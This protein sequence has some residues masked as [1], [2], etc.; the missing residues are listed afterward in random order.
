MFDNDGN[1]STDLTL[2]ITEQ[3]KNK[4]TLKVSADKKFLSDCSYPVTIDPQFTTSQNWQKSQCTYVDSSKPS[5]CFGY[6][7]TSGYTGTVNVGTWGNGMYRTYFKM[8]SL[9]TLNKGDMVV[10][11]HLNIHLMNKDFYQDM[12]IGAYSPNASWSQD[13]LTWKIS[14]HTIQRLLITKP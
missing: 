2:S 12:N 6:G 11:A 10:E 1:K 5:T 14:R 9:P 13:K 3:K 8:N 7:S 4:L